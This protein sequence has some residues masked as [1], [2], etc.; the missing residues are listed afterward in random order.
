MTKMSWATGVYG[1]VGITGMGCALGS[2][3]LEDPWVDRSHL[4]PYLI[5]SF[6]EFHT[7]SFP[8]SDLTGSF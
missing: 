2:I 1:D 5:L 6:N 3:Y 8:S 7:L 4:V